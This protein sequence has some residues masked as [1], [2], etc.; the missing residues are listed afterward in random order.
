MSKNTEKEVTVEVGLPQVGFPK[1][2]YFNRLRVD[3]EPDF[4]LVQFGLVVASDLID[5][6]SCVLTTDV[7]KQNQKT[8]IEYTSKLTVVE[9]EVP[10][11]KGI[12][13]SRNVDVIDIV[14][15]AFR[16]Q[17]SETCFF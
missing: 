14:T 16:G 3:R 10:L 17:T 8:L 12:S 5:S 11:W 9:N 7:I 6:Y 15:M 4:C 1:T 2:L 13:A